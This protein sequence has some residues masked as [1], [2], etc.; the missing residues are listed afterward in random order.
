L[1]D[2]LAVDNENIKISLIPKHFVQFFWGY[3]KAVHLSLAKYI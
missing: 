3:E 1:N 2:P